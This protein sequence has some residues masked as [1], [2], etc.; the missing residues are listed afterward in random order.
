MVQTVGVDNETRKRR[1]IPRRWI[2]VAILVL[3]VAASERWD[4]PLTLDRI[5]GGASSV[6]EAASD[7]F[8][9]DNHNQSAPQFERGDDRDAADDPPRTDGPVIHF[10]FDDGPHPVYTS[11]ILDVL[12]DHDATAVFFPVGRQVAAGAS[13]L[14]RAVAEG[15]RIGNHTWAH[16]RLAGASADR[17]DRVVGR[18]QVAVADAT[19]MVPRCL[20]PPGGEIDGRTERLAQDS[21]LRLTMW[22][23]DPQDWDE[24]GTSAI[25]ERVLARAGDGDIVLLHDGGGTQSQ[26]VTALDR[27]LDD[28]SDRGFRFT[29]VPGC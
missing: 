23:V 8:G 17:F 27:I 26:T 18:T 4:G 12:A 16:D 13:S 24:P 15:H 29:A 5:R 1:R 11:Q 6:A 10:T 3:P 21:G 7:R 20:R 25:V 2:A 28:L 19:G 9:L 22:T 14:Q